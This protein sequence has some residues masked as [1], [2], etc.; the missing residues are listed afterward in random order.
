MQ[1][2]GTDI[3]ILF[4][5]STAIVLVLI[6]VVAVVVVAYQR[7]VMA[8]KVRMQEIEAE[9][10]RQRL[11]AVV[12]TQE[13][14]RMRIA[15]D[16]HDEVGAMLS[17]VKMSIKR[18]ERKLAQEGQ[19]PPLSEATEMLDSAIGSVRA[20]SHDLLPPSLEALGLGP[21]LAQLA[22]KT[23]EMSGTPFNCVAAVDLPRL[24]I[25]AELTLYRVV[26]ELIANSLKHGQAATRQLRI[27]QAGQRLEI[28]FRDDGVGCDLKSITGS[29]GGLGLQGMASRVEALGGTLKLESS[30]GRGFS[31]VILVVH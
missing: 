25:R 7:R 14:E 10:Q 17:T 9:A 22:A 28:A 18:V 4:L 3:L 29:G 11:A 2:G 21:A 26:Q 19:E 12:D 27:C 15:R 1:E 24:P 16:L 30:P 8:Q 20:I 13:S 6:A 5:V 31:A 23:A